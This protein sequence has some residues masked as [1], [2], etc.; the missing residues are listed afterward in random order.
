[1]QG[2]W[3]YFRCHQCGRCC[4]KIGLPYDPES[5]F[6]IADALNLNVNE[7]IEAYYGKYEDDGKFWKPDDS[8]RTP[9]P[10]LKRSSNNHC[11]I[12]SVRPDG[13][14]LYP[15]ETDGGPQGIS[16]PAWETAIFMLRRE[17]EEY[18]DKIA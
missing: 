3:K 7:T 8:K 5:I 2:K 15:M 12:Y 13:C 10:F 1:M 16:C 4:D 6:K 14:R 18:V 9:C 11:N 17:Q